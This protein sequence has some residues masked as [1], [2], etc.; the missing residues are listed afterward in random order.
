MRNVPAPPREES[1]KVLVRKDA[2]VSTPLSASGR[3]ILALQA[4][5]F[6]GVAALPAANIASFKIVLP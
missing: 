5:D 1:V 6:S 4:L 2:R 3:T